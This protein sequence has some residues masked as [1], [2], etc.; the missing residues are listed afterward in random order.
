MSWEHVKCNQCKEEYRVQMYGPIKQREWKIENWNGICDECREKNRQAKNEADALRNKDAGLPDLTGSEKQIAWAETIRADKIT[1][2]E[3]QFQ[4]WEELRQSRPERLE[5]HLNKY[6]PNCD[7]TPTRMEAAFRLIQR[8]KESRFWIDNRFDGAVELLHYGL[9]QTPSETQKAEAA[10]K[11]ESAEKAQAEAQAKAEAATIRPESPKSGNPVEISVF[12]TEVSLEFE[13]NADF[14][15]LVKDAHYRW[16]PDKYI[17]ERRVDSASDRAAEIGITLLDAGF[18]VLCYNDSARDMIRRREFSPEIRKW[19]KRRIS[20]DYANCFAVSFDYDPSLTSAVKDIEGRKWDKPDWIVPGKFYA[21]V[22]EFAEKHGF[23]I[24][25]KAQELIAQAVR[26][27]QEAAVAYQ[28]ALSDSRATEADISIPAPEGLQYL[29]YQKAGVTFALDREN[30]LIADEMGLGKTIQAIGIINA[31]PDIENALVI[32]PANLRINWQRETEKWLVRDISVGIATGKKWPETNLVI[33]NYDILPKHYEKLREKE[34]DIIIVDESQ[35]LKNAKALRSKHVF[36]FLTDKTEITPIPA[37]RKIFLSGTPILNRPA[38]AWTTVHHLA[39][40]TFPK[41]S[42]FVTRYCN[43]YKT[44]FEWD[45]PGAS[46]LDELQEKLRTSIMVRRLKK[47]VLPELPEKRRQVIELP[48]N[49]CKKFVNAEKKAWKQYQKTLA[50]L[51][52]AVEKAEKGSQVY[53]EAVNALKAGQKATFEEM[54]KLRHETARAKVPYVVEHLSNALENG[55]V[56]C[57]AHHKDVIDAI[58]AEFDCCVTL[59]GDTKTEDRQAAVDRF[60]N[61]PDCKLFIGNIKAAGVG[62]TLTASD[63]CVFGEI[64]QVPVELSQA[65]DRL[66]RIGQKNG[67]LVQHLVLESSLDA[68]MAKTLIEKQG[69]LHEA[70]DAVQE[71][72]IALMKG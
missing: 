66:H 32:C 5:K 33:I 31:V 39:P 62:I 26:Q 72:W 19:V 42:D 1:E 3:E 18:S 37:R 64:S 16:N 6:F 7:P 36:G 53:D 4:K 69:V 52:K 70:L 63:H 71:E 27:E 40:K 59:T 29:P 22:T 38:E 54:A 23:A 21:Q 61:D 10:V 28:K 25:P 48:T 45:V 55:K 57:F 44:N 9:K 68:T 20:G 56:V 67:V 2:I 49:G 24:S 11:A 47:D 13:K 17:W 46:H 30:T 50:A 15:E 41:W 58:A 14:R 12:K 60:Q 8:Q 34:W 65:E 51:R 35:Y 43:G